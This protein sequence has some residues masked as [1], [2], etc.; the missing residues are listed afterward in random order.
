[1]GRKRSQVS[2]VEIKEKIPG[3]MVKGSFRLKQEIKSGEE[4]N[5][6]LAELG[7]DFIPDRLILRP[8]KEQCDLS[9][10]KQ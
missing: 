9:D 10:G 6:S 7:I 3:K 1:M 2:C 8:V 4:I 5:I